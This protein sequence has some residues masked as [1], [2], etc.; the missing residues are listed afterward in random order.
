MSQFSP[1]LQQSTMTEAKTPSRKSTISKSDTL[2]QQ[3]RLQLY[4]S[5]FG[6]EKNKICDKTGLQ[7]TSSLNYSLYTFLHLSDKYWVLSLIDIESFD[8][9][10][11]KYGT[12]KVQ[13]KLNQIGTV[14]K[15]FSD[16]NPNK[17]KGYKCN[18]LVYES[19]D[20]DCKHDIFSLL[21][22]CYPK[23]E[24]SEKYISKLIKKIQQQ[25]NET[26]FVG[27]AKMNEW[28]TFEQWKARAFKN[29][30]N[31]LNATTTDTTNNNNITFFSDVGVNYVNPNKNEQDEKQQQHG[32]DGVVNKKMGNK[33][34][35][36]LKMKEIANNEEYE[37]LVAIMAVDDYDSFVFSK[38]GNKEEVDREIEKMKTATFRLFDIYG[39]GTNIQELKYFAYNL[40]RAGKFGLILY[41]SK[42]LSKCFVPGHEI[43]ET[44][45][46]EISMKCQFTVSIGCSRLMEDDWGM[47]DDWIERITN[48]L[49]QAKKEGKNGICFHT[50][51]DR[52]DNDDKE[53]ESKFNVVNINGDDIIKTKSLTEID[54]CE[55]RVHQC[56][57]C[58]SVCVILT[59]C[60]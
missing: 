39:N 18:D 52:T 9:L 60:A 24:I 42:D 57:Y 34:R 56:L 13:N 32:A 10:Q 28:E 33:E 30:K 47:T 38:D 49:K 29:L 4:N 20:D 17:L 14:V 53:L 35:F 40:G 12:S 23:V 48:N 22:Y 54:V 7:F 46:E 25:T 55:L 50:R 51:S 19:D 11:E 37:W 31:A 15:N 6:Q 45:Q 27:I 41:D 5:L 44:L 26:V 58:V 2:P 8:I 43:V 3:Q 1:Q 16:N 21:M 59:V 36:D